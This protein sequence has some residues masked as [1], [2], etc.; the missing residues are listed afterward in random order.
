MEAQ[1]SG[2]ENQVRQDTFLIHLASSLRS[3]FPA[4]AVTASPHHLTGMPQRPTDRSRPGSRLET[5]KRQ[6]VQRA[7]RRPSR[8]PLHWHRLNRRRHRL[9]SRLHRCHS[10]GRRRVEPL[11]PD[12]A[13]GQSPMRPPLYGMRIPERHSHRNMQ[14]Q[15]ERTGRLQRCQAGARVRGQARPSA[16]LPPGR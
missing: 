11:V 4:T 5:K 13:P 2:V 6:P 7:M 10:L 8:P 12:A 14:H 15:V 16:G 9:S 3:A 1:R